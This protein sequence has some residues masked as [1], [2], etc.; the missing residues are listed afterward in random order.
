MREFG[1][2]FRVGDIP[3]GRHI[4]IV[5]R[6]RILQA[7]LF[8]KGDRDMPGVI[9]SAKGALAETLER[10]QGEHRDTVIAPS[11]RSMRHVHSQNA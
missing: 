3:A 10:Y 2:H 9:E 1:I 5:D 6:N 11:G 4:E 7:G 8:P